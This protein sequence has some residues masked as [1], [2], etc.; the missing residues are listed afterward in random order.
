MN[1]DFPLEAE[2]VIC[3]KY[4]PCAS[5]DED[6]KGAVCSECIQHIIKANQVMIDDLVQCGILK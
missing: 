5:R 3:E 1:Q 4:L 6:L 2:C